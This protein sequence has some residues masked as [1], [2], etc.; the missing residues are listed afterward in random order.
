[1]KDFPGVSSGLTE[2]SEDKLDWG[3]QE[4]GTHRYHVR[5]LLED[6][7]AQLSSFDKAAVLGA[8]NH[9]DVDLP[10]LAS[11]FSQLTV[12]DTEANAIEEFME[13]TGGFASPKFKSLAHVD[14]TCLDQL[15]FYQDYEEKLQA[16]IPA[17]ELAGWLRDQAFLVKREEALP[18]MKKSFNLVVSSGVHTQ[19]FYLHALSQLAEYMHLY[20]EADT[21]QIVEALGFLRNSVVADYNTLLTSL[22]K[23]EGRVAAW[24]DIILLDES[25][26]DLLDQL[27]QL[28]NDNERVRFLFQAFGKYGIESAVIGL[29]DLFDKLKPEQQL[30][31][32]WVWHTESGKSYLVA[33]LSGRVRA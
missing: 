9:G 30:F 21:A 31:K 16:G 20:N 10:E 2:V 7:T 24:T 25:K 12:L 29:K 17:G 28:N 27:N 19:L 33:G 13:A 18:H 26:K 32:S 11:R 4:W 5:K 14:Y 3:E 23:P 6:T 15:G 22:V 1:M 8:G